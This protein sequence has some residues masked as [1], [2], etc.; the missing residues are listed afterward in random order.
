MLLSSWP[1]FLGTNPRKAPEN[2]A[3]FN[4]LEL[5]LRHGVTLDASRMR[6]FYATN[7]F[8]EI[9]KGDTQ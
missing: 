8:T 4:P 2:D 6:E 9:V 3:G 5:Q 1:P 7:P